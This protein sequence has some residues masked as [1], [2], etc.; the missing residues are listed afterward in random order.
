MYFGFGRLALH[1]CNEPGKPNKMRRAGSL[2]QRAG[3]SARQ[4]AC[5]NCVGNPRGK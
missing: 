4:I 5:E 1:P 3:R 2:M